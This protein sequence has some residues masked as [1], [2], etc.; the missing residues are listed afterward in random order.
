MPPGR[1]YTQKLYLIGSIPYFLIVVSW[2]LCGRTQ[3]KPGEIDSLGFTKPAKLV[4]MKSKEESRDAI[5][6]KTC[7]SRLC[8][9]IPIQMPLPLVS[10]PSILH[11]TFANHE[12]PVQV[13]EGAGLG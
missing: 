13:P 1:S 12:L 2:V 8:K 10:S 5:C 9:F 11:V 4:R 7:P 6:S 3:K